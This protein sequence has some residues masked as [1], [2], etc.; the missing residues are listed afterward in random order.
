MVVIVIVIGVVVILID[1]IVIVVVVV[2]LLLFVVCCWLFLL[3]FVYVVFFWC[4][5][6]LVGN[7][8]YSAALAKK[9]IPQIEKFKVKDGCCHSEEAVSKSLHKAARSQSKQ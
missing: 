7:P 6:Q 3:L 8:D 5:K 1:M 2:C 4:P 9:V